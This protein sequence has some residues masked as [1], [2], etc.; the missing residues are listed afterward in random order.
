MVGWPRH[1]ESDVDFEGFPRTWHEDTAIVVRAR[2]D[3]VGVVETVA[4][5]MGFVEDVRWR[6]SLT[7]FTYP[8]LL[9]SELSLDS[10]GIM[11]HIFTSFS[12]VC[13]EWSMSTTK[14][15]PIAKSTVAYSPLDLVKR[16]MFSKV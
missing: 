8:Y 4:A 10:R 1:G 2:I 11:I 3:V 12:P 13:P 6:F 7:G 9:K 16:R 14:S 15:P 5:L